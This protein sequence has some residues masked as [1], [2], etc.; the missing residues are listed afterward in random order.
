MR[1]LPSSTLIGAPSIE[2]LPVGATLLTI[3]WKPTVS[4]PPSPSSAVIVTVWLS[5]GPSSVVNDH[6]HVLGMLSQSVAGFMFRS[7]PSWPFGVE[8][9]A[10]GLPV[11]SLNL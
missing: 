10:V 1:G 8:S 9:A 7:V 3:S 2:K 5:A 6:V 4:V 11:P